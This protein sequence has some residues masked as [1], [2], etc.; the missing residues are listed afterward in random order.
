MRVDLLDFSVVIVQGADGG[1]CE[2]CEGF[3]E[4]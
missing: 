4:Y 1:L 2:S 3:I